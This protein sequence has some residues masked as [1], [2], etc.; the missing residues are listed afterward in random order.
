MSIL[1]YVPEG[2]NTDESDIR[3]NEQKGI[4]LDVEKFWNRYDVIVIPAAVGTGKSLIA[5]TIARWRE[6]FEESTGTITHRV[7]LQEQ[8]EK[9]FPD[10]DIL[11]GKARY[12]C[13]EGFGSCQEHFELFEGYCDTCP[14][15]RAKDNCLKATNAV[16]NFQSYI[17]HKA[18]KDN[19]IVDEAQNILPIMGET[20]SLTLWKHVHNYPD[21]I[22]THGDVA[23]WLEAQIK[24]T[25]GEIDEARAEFAKTRKGVKGH[26]IPKKHRLAAATYRNLNR[27]EKK[28]R[29]VLAGL[30]RAPMHY[31]IEHSEESYRNEPMMALKVRPTTLRD[32]PE[33]L[34]PTSST[35]KIVLMSGTIEQRDITELGLHDRKVKFIDTNNPIEPDRRQI[36]VDNP[37]NMSWRYQDKNMSA[38]IAQIQRIMNSYPDTKGMVHMTYGLA[39]KMKGLLKDERIMWHDREDKEAV[40]AT[41]KASEQ[42]KV[43]VACGMSEGVDLAGPD[44]SFQIIAKVQWPSS[45]DKMID[46]FYKKDIER[47]IWDTVRTIRQQAGRICRGAD[48][49]G[50]TYIIDA[51]FGNV[52]KKRKGLFQRSRQFWPEDIVK[53]IKWE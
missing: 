16:F 9:S 39:K 41:F 51:A 43:M 17:L 40:L 25:E 35:K 32:M 48:D 27:R 31:F 10:V 26:R 23:M 37:H 50:I 36:I 38:V 29:Q 2:F 34:W 44:F 53:S 3:W 30:Q 22:E 12:T 46:M 7:A 20:F 45:A 24:I 19:L 42:P 6:S 8:Y 49:M 52:K 4:L 28:Y 5:Q 14:Y 13:V 47:V 11:M 18:Y 33:L 15:A 21:D 1:N